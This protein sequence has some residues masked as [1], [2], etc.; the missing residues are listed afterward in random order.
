[1]FPSVLSSAHCPD[2]KYP[3]DLKVCVKEGGWWM[4]VKDSGRK[5]LDEK[6]NMGLL[7]VVRTLS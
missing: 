1:M 2:K 4:T 5:G 6:K 3:M 7:R